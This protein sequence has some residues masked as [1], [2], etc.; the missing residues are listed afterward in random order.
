M[1]NKDSKA[2]VHLASQSDLDM[3]AKIRNDFLIDCG[4]ADSEETIKTLEANF[5]RYYLK[6]LH[7]ALLPFYAK[8]D[9]SIVSTAFLDITDAFPMPSCPSGCYGTIYN[10]FTYPKYRSKGYAKHVIEVLIEEAKQ[11]D[12]SYVTLSASVLGRP[13]YEKF[14]FAQIQLSEHYIDMKLFLGENS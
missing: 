14:G 12:L 8:I 7:S 11:R 5:R 2:T 13:L 9:D 4:F 3:M 10:V 1:T 6:S